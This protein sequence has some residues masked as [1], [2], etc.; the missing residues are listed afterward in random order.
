MRKLAHIVGVTIVFFAASTTAFSADTSWSGLYKQ[1]TDLYTQG[2]WTE[3]MAPATAALKA[4]P[5]KIGPNSIYVV[6]SL[7]LLGDLKQGSWKPGTSRSL[8]SGILGPSGEAFRSRSC[9]YP[10]SRYHRR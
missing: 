1:A 2:K 3:A 9:H 10:R 5:T 4:A 7:T 8:L 6:K